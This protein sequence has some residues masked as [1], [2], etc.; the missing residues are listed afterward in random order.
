V[1]CK[2][3]VVQFK[4][5]SEFFSKIKSLI[6]R[7]DSLESKVEFFPENDAVMIK[8]ITSHEEPEFELHI[9][10]KI[11]SDLQIAVDPIFVNKKQVRVTG[12][13]PDTKYILK[14][15]FNFSDGLSSMYLEECT[16][17][18]LSRNIKVTK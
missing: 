12:L 11:G 6:T 13:E 16:F 10:K 9:F 2:D 3:Q 14:Y 5:A 18:T 4:S 7:T 1:L 8:F 15:R 17:Q